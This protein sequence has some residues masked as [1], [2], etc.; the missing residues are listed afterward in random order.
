[1]RNKTKLQTNRVLHGFAIIAAWQFAAFF[2]LLL[3]IWVNEVFNLAA[4][5]YGAERQ[6]PNYFSAILLS[7]FVILMAIV[8]VSQTYMKQK[9]IIS[10]MLTVCMKCHKVRLNDEVWQNIENYLADRNPVEFS[11]GYCPKCFEEEME[12]V[13]STVGM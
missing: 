8:I 4:L 13:N 12:I 3:L 1:M 2:V 11:H 9:Q 5:V 10:G 6:E 7:L